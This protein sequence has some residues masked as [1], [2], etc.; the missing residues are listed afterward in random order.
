MPKNLVKVYRNN[1]SYSRHFQ[2][3]NFVEGLPVVF[4]LLPNKRS[5]TY[6]ELFERL[7]DQAI[8]MKKEFNPKRIITDFEPGLLSIIQ[9]EVNILTLIINLYTSF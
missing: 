1:I 5:K 3:F 8:V 7:K 6:L 9:Q 2:S 4:C